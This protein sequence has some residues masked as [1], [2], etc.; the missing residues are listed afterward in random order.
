M[1]SKAAFIVGT[2]LGYVLGTRAGRQQLEK[3]K[4]WTREVWEDPRLQA[5]VNDFGSKATE[6]AKT[7]GSA[8]KDKVTGTVKSVVGS[9]DG[10]ADATEDADAD[11]D[12]PGPVP[13]NGSHVADE[14]A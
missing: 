10:G 14:P 13:A 12:G 11:A 5:H 8:L 1:K 4:G 2:G 6:F 3:F 9:F 7:E